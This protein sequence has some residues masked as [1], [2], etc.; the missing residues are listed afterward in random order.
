MTETL[1]PKFSPEVE[2][3]LERRRLDFY[4][5]Y[6]KQL[7]FHQA[8]G[9]PG[10]DSRLLMAANQVGKT[11][12]A[13]AEVSMHLTGL[14]PEW[15]TGHRF[16]GPNDWWVASTTSQMTR[17]NPQ[18]LLMGRG[19]QNW[20]TGMLPGRLIKTIKK[21]VHGVPESIELVT[22]KHQPT[23]KDSTIV[24]KTYDQG[25]QR[26]QGETLDGIWDDEEPPEEIYDEGKVR[27]QAKNGIFIMT[28]T[29]FLGMSQVVLRF[30][31]KKIPGG[32][33]INMTID[34]ALHYT[35]AQRA[36]II[37]GYPAH[38]RE[39]RSRGIPAMGS[40]AVF[41]VDE[42][43]LKEP[44]IQIPEFWPSISGL[45]I[46]WDHPTAAA[47]IAWDKDVDI[48]HVY[49][50]YRMAQ[51]TPIVHAAAIKARG[52]WI[53]MA[54]PHDGLQ[55]DK[56]SG[57]VIA[58]QYAKQG[59]NMLRGHATH[60]PQPGK[61]EGS[62]GY[63]L[64]AGILEMLA[65]MQT[66]RFKVASTL[67][68]WFEEYRMYYRDEKGL[69]VKEGDDLMSAT[70]VATMMMRHAKLRVD[71]SEAPILPGFRQTDITMGV[72]G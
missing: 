60:P 68:D 56:G 40:G 22:V 33:V 12:S 61:K 72:L 11:L 59:V 16:A 36:K 47:W 55:H 20:G 37:E 1:D 49:D 29:P 66:G 34:D 53:P 2:R 32:M 39:A 64:E 9:L 8:G 24:Y 13:S 7:L 67:A 51:Q 26:W 71:R 57:I 35:P 27:L 48:L 18:R 50:C 46:G 31:K 15:W 25:R 21:A 69:I 38:E 28:F 52:V 70:R 43:L 42:D 17:D 5:P 63:G 10:I 6:P 14:Y 58:S 23:G 54:W 62:G 3:A 41:P 45:D 19:E 30:L 44:P 4:T 65:R